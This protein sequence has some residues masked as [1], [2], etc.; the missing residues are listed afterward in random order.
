MIPKYTFVTYY[1]LHKYYLK[2]CDLDSMSW[3]LLIRNVGVISRVFWYRIWE[4]PAEVSEG[5]PSS[6]GTKEKPH[7]ASFTWFL[8]EFS[9]LIAFGL[10][11]FGVFIAVS[12]EI[13]IILWHAPPLPPLLVRQ[14]TMWWLT[15]FV[16]VKK[17]K[18]TKEF[19]KC[20]FYNLTWEMASH[21]PIQGTLI[22]IKSFGPSHIKGS[23]KLPKDINMKSQDRW[24]PL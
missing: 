23:W 9:P 17:V 5:L 6:E 7:P 14:L 15:C 1:L 4:Y 21:H 8:A 24:D 13:P 18:R 2:T 3:F 22:M 11:C 12:L 16:R 20:P 19:H 10:Q